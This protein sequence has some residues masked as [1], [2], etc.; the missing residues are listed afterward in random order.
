MRPAGLLPLPVARR[1][2]PCPRRPGAPLVEL[3]LAKNHVGDAGAIRLAQAITRAE[4]QR[5]AGLR[6]LVLAGNADIGEEGAQALLEAARQS[7]TITTMD[8]RANKAIATLPAQ[9]KPELSC[10]WVLREA[11]GWRT[12]SNRQRLGA[13]LAEAQKA[14]S[15]LP[16][17]HTSRAELAATA[18]GGCDPRGMEAVGLPPRV[19]Q[20]RAAARPRRLR[21]QGAA[22][23]SG[24][25]Q[26]GT[27]SV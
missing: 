18:L 17:P 22:A 24:A 4:Q 1:L 25:G 2:T 19:E 6:T 9:L 12:E 7:A 5:G 21:C 3:G 20:A 10:N 15:P 23:A 13:L 8:V 16:R 27:V 26:T 14:V 11:D